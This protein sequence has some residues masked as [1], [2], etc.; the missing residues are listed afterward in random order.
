VETKAREKV[1]EKNE[2]RR[3]RFT[4]EEYHL[5]GEAG[6]F[7]EGERVEL[8]EGEVVQMNPIGSRH[9]ACV[10]ILTRLLGRS[11]DDE[12]FLDVQNPVKIN[13]GLEPQPDLMV[14]RA[15]DY[16]DSLP[17]PEDVLLLIEVSDTTLSYDRNVKL[18]LYAKAGIRESWI[19]DLAGESIERHNDPSQTGYGRMQRVGPE[20]T[21]ASEAFSDLILNTDSLIG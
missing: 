19:V 2:I 4:A 7:G 3:R 11:L 14:V 21:L 16:K 9:A 17:G 10:R 15:R 20:K 8:I 13:G 1:R 6:I 5:M 18:P 12:F